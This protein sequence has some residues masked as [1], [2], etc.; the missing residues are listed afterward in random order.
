MPR[1]RATRVSQIIVNRRKVGKRQTTMTTGTQCSTKL[2]G[3]RVAIFTS[4]APLNITFRQ[5]ASDAVPTIKID[6]ESIT[7]ESGVDFTGFTFSLSG[8]T[9]NGGVRCA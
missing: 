4:T 7:N 9:S 6:D 1:V 2:R 5:V 8:G 3:T